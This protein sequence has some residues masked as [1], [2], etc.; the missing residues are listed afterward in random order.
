[1][2]KNVT[3]FLVTRTAKSECGPD[4]DHTFSWNVWGWFKSTVLG[5]RCHEERKNEK[6]KQMRYGKQY[7][8]K[9]GIDSET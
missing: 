5:Q 4:G 8:L 2:E 6:E 7:G 9:N 3:V 1:M